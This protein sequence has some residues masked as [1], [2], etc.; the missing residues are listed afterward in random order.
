MPKHSCTEKTSAEK[1]QKLAAIEQG[2]LFLC[3]LLFSALIK[4]KMQKGSDG[5][6]GHLWIVDTLIIVQRT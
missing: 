3:L 1:S 4:S 5:Y 6:G 2:D